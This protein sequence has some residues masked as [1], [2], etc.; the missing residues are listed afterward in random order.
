[1]GKMMSSRE[2]ALARLALREVESIRGS[3]E[4]FCQY[5]G[6]MQDGSELARVSERMY[7]I[8]ETA[9]QLGEKLEK[10]LQPFALI[11]VAEI[12]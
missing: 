2:I 3:V 11:A 1:M 9:D 8:G 12:Y 7:R 10:M 5:Y 6:E 4:I